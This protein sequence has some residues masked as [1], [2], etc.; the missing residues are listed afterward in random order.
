MIKDVNVLRHQS[1]KNTLISRKNGVLRKKLGAV[2]TLLN[3]LFVNCCRKNSDG[4][5]SKRNNEEAKTFEK[6]T[7]N[8]KSDRDRNKHRHDRRNS[9]S[10]PSQEKRSTTIPDWISL[11]LFSVTPHALKIVVLL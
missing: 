6:R 1:I 8:H 4:S 9:E 3:L 10:F 5:D 7:Q 2:L 11:E